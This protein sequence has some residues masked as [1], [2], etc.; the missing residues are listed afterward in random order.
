MLLIRRFPLRLF[1]RNALSPQRIFKAGGGFDLVVGE[2]GFRRID[3][4][5]EEFPHHARRGKEMISNRTALHA[6]LLLA[7]LHAALPVEAKAAVTSHQGA[8]HGAKFQSGNEP[9]TRR[10]FSLL[11][12]QCVFEASDQRRTLFWRQLVE[13]HLPFLM[14]TPS[15]VLPE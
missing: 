1:Q 8:E 11:I 9:S 12:A 5:D 3:R 14:T 2:F 6:A 15:P 7:A 13:V 10:R 4:F